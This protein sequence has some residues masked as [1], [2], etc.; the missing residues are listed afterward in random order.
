MA[1]EP[2][3]LLYDGDCALCAHSV[4]FLAPRDPHAR[5]RYAAIAGPHGAPHARAAGL[6]PAAPDTLLLIA[7]GKTFAYSDAVLGAFARIKAPW[8]LVARVGQ[9]VPRAWRDGL[10]RLVAENRYRWFGRACLVPGP[11]W[12][13]RVLD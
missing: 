6:D 7:D 9:F 3:L 13:S 12:A 8:P 11:N 5:I 1:K 10:Y 4:R 2:V